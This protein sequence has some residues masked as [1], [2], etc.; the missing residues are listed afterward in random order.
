MAKKKTKSKRR[1]GS[2]QPRVHSVS[3][4]LENFRLAKARRALTLVIKSK[5]EKIGEMHLGSGSIFWWG[6]H[7]KEYARLTWGKFAEI[8]NEIAYGK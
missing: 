3:A 6:R 7:R 8:M 1:D 4:E 5:G 2:K